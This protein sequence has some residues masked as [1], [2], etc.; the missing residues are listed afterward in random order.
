M[1]RA[2]YGRRTTDVTKPEQYSKLKMPTGFQMI[3]FGI[4][5][6]YNQSILKALADAS[7]GTLHNITDARNS[8]SPA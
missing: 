1:D 8:S 5:A 3:E 6:D 7:G 2:S 4:G